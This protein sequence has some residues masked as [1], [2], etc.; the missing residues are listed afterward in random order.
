[1]TRHYHA[2]GGS[3]LYIFNYTLTTFGSRR[4]RDVSTPRP[5]HYTGSPLTTSYTHAYMSTCEIQTLGKTT[6][7]KRTFRFLA[8]RESMLQ[9]IHAEQHLTQTLRELSVC[10]PLLLLLAHT[11]YN[12]R[13]KNLQFLDSGFTQHECDYLL[14]SYATPVSCNAMAASAYNAVVDSALHLVFAALNRKG[15]FKLCRARASQ[16]ACRRQQMKMCRHCLMW[17]RSSR[18]C[19][20]QRIG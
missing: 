14:T 1:M 20:T 15:M 6:T 2:F 7:S 19:A 16:Q 3:L 9:N 12:P 4:Q 17:F 8:G 11:S 5:L 18:R 13:R 10:L